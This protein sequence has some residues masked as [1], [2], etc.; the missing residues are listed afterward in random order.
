MAQYVQLR[1]LE[2]MEHDEGAAYKDQN[3]GILHKTSR[4][5]SLAFS[6]FSGVLLT[7]VAGVCFGFRQDEPH[8][9]ILPILSKLPRM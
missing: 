7:A 8:T 2:Q 4:H 1:N 9:E 5:R 6:F 3:Q